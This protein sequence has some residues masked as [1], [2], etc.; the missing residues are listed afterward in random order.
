M[1]EL[2]KLKRQELAVLINVERNG[3]GDVYG[4]APQIASLDEAKLNYQ[5]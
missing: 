5:K 4:Y 2:A 1:Q 3:T